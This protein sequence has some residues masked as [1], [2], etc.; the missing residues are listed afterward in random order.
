MPEDRRLHCPEAQAG[1]PS[2]ETR[3]T[4]ALMRIM[5]GK[6]CCGIVARNRVQA[7]RAVSRDGAAGFWGEQWHH[8]LQ[9]RQKRGVILSM[10]VEHLVH[11]LEPPQVGF[12]D[13]SGLGVIPA[14]RVPSP[15]FSQPTMPESPSIMH[16]DVPHVQVSVGKCDFDAR[17][18][19]RHSA[20]RRP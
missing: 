1:G 17:R 7:S 13:V 14:F 10:A 18:D 16:E 3:A 6:T 4:R 15:E 5:Y 11:E 20:V 12:G 19:G 9:S 2:V 8:A